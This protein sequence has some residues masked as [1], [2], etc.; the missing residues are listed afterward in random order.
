MPRLGF[1]AHNIQISS[2]ILKFQR[3]VRPDLKSLD[4]EGNLS[5]RLAMLGPW[6]ARFE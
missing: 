1:D 2:D 6:D 4:G 5:L 3:I